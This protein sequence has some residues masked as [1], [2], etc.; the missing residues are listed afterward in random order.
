MTTIYIKETTELPKRK[1]KD[2]YPT[3]DQDLIRRAILQYGHH[4][5]GDP[6]LDPG[7]G[8]GRWG[9]MVKELYPSAEIHGVEVRRV[10][11]PEGFDRWW[12]RKDF[13]KFYPGVTYSLVVGNPPYG[14]LIDNIPQAEH[15]IRHG[16]ELLAP[17][18]R[19]IYL[20]PLQIQAGVGR[21]N[22]LWVE[23]PPTLVAVVSPR[24]S[25][26][27]NKHGRRGTNGTDYGL[28]IWDKSLDGRP[29]GTPRAW[30]CELFIYEP[31]R[32]QS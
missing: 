15:F 8:D 9:R 25:F 21:Y 19:M 32:G 24:P 3:E 16:F 22:G 6:V 14:P 28:F 1:R 29:V 30:P 7:A 11:R 31:E 13:L 12:K 17:G 27:R 10:P 2:F 18:G 26:G 20:L 5:A 23:L 4:P